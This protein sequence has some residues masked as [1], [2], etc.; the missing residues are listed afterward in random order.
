LVCGFVNIKS[1]SIFDTFV[2]IDG[3]VPNFFKFHEAFPVIPVDLQIIPFSIF[4]VLEN[5]AGRI[6]T[7]FKLP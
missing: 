5:D 2:N 7:I 6:S 3:A 1:S 4:Q